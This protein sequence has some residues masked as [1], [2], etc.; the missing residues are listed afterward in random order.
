MKKLCFMI[1]ICLAA[2][3]SLEA[4]QITRFAVVDLPKVY[5]AF[6]RESRAV[7][8]FE[9]RSARVQA[10][11]DRMTGEIQTLRVNMV[12]AQA[13]GN[14]DQ[15]LRMEA[16]INRRSEI[17]REFHRTRT[18]DLETQRARLTQSDTFLSQVYD[19][20]RFIAE[21]EGFSMVLNLNNNNSIVWFSPTV[22]ITDK[23]ISNLLAN[24][25]R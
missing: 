15:A 13:A 4:Q 21:S 14:E 6:F 25:N 17:L 8:D 10:D 16:E 12:N 24:T 23:L 2:S 18:A 9:A 5:M 19:E 3:L 11:I 1:F 20:I 22:D 7:R